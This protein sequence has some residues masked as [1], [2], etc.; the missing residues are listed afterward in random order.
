M[1]ENKFKVGDKVKIIS[2]SWGY[3]DSVINNLGIIKNIDTGEFTQ[4]PYY[5]KIINGGDYIWLRERDVDLL[6]TPITNKKVINSKLLKW[7]KKDR[8]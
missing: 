2:E 6:Y 5:V 1:E 8:I 3:R 4:Y 7:L